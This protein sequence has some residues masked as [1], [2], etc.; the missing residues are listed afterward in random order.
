[1][2]LDN[3]FKENIFEYKIIGLVSINKDSQKDNY[4]RTKKD[5]PNYEKKII[6]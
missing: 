2:S 3:I 6:I 4:K 1:M 5:Y